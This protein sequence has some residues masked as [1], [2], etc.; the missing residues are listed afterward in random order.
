MITEKKIQQFIYSRRYRPLDLQQLAEALNVSSGDF[1]EL[2]QK[3]DDLERRGEVVR[4]NE[5]LY[6][7]P[8][9]ENLIVG[10]LECHHSG[11]GFIV[12]PDKHRRDYYVAAEDMASGMHGDTVVAR[13]K[14]TRRRGRSRRYI[15]GGKRGANAQVAKVLQRANEKIIGRFQPTHG[16]YQRLIPDDPRVFQTIRLTIPKDHATPR[17]GEKVAAEMVEWPSHY[18]EAEARLLEVL[19]PEGSPRVDFYQV[20]LEHGIAREFPERVTAVADEVPEEIPQDTLKRRRDLRAPLTITIDPENAK[21]FDDA[22]SLYVD[23]QTGNR[24][25]LV[26]IADVGYFVRPDSVLDAEARER[27]LSIYLANTVVPMLPQRLS[28]R[29]CSLLAGEERLAKTVRME[30]D[31]AGNLLDSCII[32]S[33]IRVDHR[34]NFT[35]VNDVLLGVDADEAAAR[36]I[37]AQ[38]VDAALLEMLVGLDRLAAQLKEQRQASGS[39]DLDVPD[40]DVMMDSEGRVL[41][42]N[43]I[44]RDRSNSLIEE[45]ML[46]ANRVVARFMVDKQIPGVFR[47]HDKPDDDAMDLFRDFVKAVLGRQIDPHDRKQ[48]QELVADVA[49]TPV[50][51]AVNMQL[52]RSFKRAQYQTKASPH[53][54]LHFDLY[55]HFT[56]PVRRYPDLVVHQLLDEYFAGKLAGARHTAEW[57]SKAESIAAHSTEAEY[58]ATEAEREYTKISLLRFMEGR[59]GEVFDA[60]ITGLV[61]FGFF[62]QIVEIPVEGLVKLHSL[63]EDYYRLSEKL[64]ALV[65]SRKGRMFRLGD[66]V[67]VRLD[68]INVNR[69]QADFV[70]VK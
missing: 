6:R 32:S 11:F 67:R 18:H 52:L 43:R 12:T 39:I 27:G 50:A 59:I 63:S 31:A 15:P 22:V 40:F 1:G 30:F 55:C 60:V 51:E 36:A 56:S 7:N 34:M 45:L 16:N 49:G 21:D 69:R 20:L 38:K 8:K 28:S 24:V 37:T 58:R 35:E 10:R 66:R 2:Q 70:L 33:L 19:G 44:V 62:V 65:G 3:L 68:D 42:V 23:S 14:Q 48:L 64:H 25:C 5:G 29:L 46:M 26:S 4:L 53:Y 47:V 9:K 17:P 54:A 13:L 57:R 61:D 41:S